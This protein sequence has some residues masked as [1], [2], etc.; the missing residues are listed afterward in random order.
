MWEIIKKKKNPQR[1]SLRFLWQLERMP[2][3]KVK[4]LPGFQGRKEVLIP[5]LLIPPGYP[6]LLS[7]HSFLPVISRSM[8]GRTLVVFLADGRNSY[9]N[10]CNS[11]PQYTLDAIV[12]HS[13]ETYLNSPNFLLAP[14]CVAAGSRACAYFGKFIPICLRVVAQHN[15]TIFHVILY[16]IANFRE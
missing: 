8:R 9:S 7:Q 1:V 11:L 4:G 2:K 14:A 13:W 12:T 5:F 6:P 16:F 3:R 10:S 15:R